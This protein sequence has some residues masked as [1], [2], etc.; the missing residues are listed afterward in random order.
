MALD[1]LVEALQ[2]AHMGLRLDTKNLALKSEWESIKEKLMVKEKQDELKRIK[3]QEKLENET[4]L[5]KAIEVR[6]YY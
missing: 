5:A 1:R 3:E 4:A 2:M 6:L